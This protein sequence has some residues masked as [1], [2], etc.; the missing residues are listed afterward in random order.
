MTRLGGTGIALGLAAAAVVGGSAAASAS[1]PSL[2]PPMPIHKVACTA[3]A[4]TVRYKANSRK[5]CYEGLGTIRVSI[6]DVDRVTTGVNSGRFIARRRGTEFLVTFTAGRTITVSGNPTMVTL[7][8][9]RAPLLG[10]RA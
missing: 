9:T 8:I 6:P 5:V 1:V 2:I 4:F 7:S 3:T 10:S